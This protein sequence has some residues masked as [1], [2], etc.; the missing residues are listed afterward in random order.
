MSTRS[1]RSVPDDRLRPGTD[2][3]NALRLFVEFARL[4]SD[5]PQGGQPPANLAQR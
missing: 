4:V 1:K 5:A 2:T 3:E